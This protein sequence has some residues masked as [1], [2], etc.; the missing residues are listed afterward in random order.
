M[1]TVS[2]AGVFRQAAEL[3]RSVD[4]IPGALARRDPA[5][6]VGQLEGLARRLEERAERVATQLRRRF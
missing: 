6:M 1:T 5:A 2:E 4:F 3:R